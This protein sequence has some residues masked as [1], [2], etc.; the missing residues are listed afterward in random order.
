MEIAFNQDAHE[1]LV[2]VLNASREKLIKLEKWSPQ[3]ANDYLSNCYIEI[4][5]NIISG[6]SMY[7]QND[8]IVA[9]QNFISEITDGLSSGLRR[10]LHL[11]NRLRECAEQLLTYTNLYFP[12]FHQL[13]NDA[14]KEMLSTAKSADKL[15]HEGLLL[16]AAAT[17]PGA[18]NEICQKLRHYGKERL[19]VPDDVLYER[20]LP[21]INMHA[22]VKLG[23]M[24]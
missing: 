8:G 9:A 13:L 10:K 18:R 23:V 14:Y 17:L 5:S 21:I 1:F 6:S 11:K 24:K 22:L 2:E 20:L 7:L 3:E 16:F 12:N 19:L 15:Q 4:N